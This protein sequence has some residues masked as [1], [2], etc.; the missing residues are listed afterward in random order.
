MEAAHLLRDDPVEFWMVGP[1]QIPVPPVLKQSPKIKWL[2]PVPRGKAAKF[3]Q[4]AD[5][6]IFPTFSDGFG[7]TQLE[8]QAW[9]LPVVASRFCGEVVEH[10]VNGVVLEEISGACI[11][12]HLI[13]LLKTPS[14]LPKMCAQSYVRDEFSLPSLG[15]RLTSL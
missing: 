4:D 13:G 9:K 12:R 15:R 1:I 14:E 7:L 2:G 10:G 6:F 11:A 5:V 8:A 3:Y